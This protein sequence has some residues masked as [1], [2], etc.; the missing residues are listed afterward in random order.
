MLECLEKENQQ[1]IK[2]A[3]TLKTM[4]YQ[5]IYDSII[6]R[7]RTRGLDKNALDYYTEKHHA[8]PRCMGGSNDNSNLVLLTTREHY[9]CHLIL[10]VLHPDI[11]GLSCAVFFMVNNPASK[12]VDKKI[13]KNS[14]IFEQLRV[15]IAESKRGKTTSDKQKEAARR[16]GKENAPFKGKDMTG[17]NNLSAKPVRDSEGKIFPTTKACAKAHNHDVET[18]RYWCR[19]G[20]NGFSYI[21]REEAM[22]ELNINESAI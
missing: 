1:Y 6:E 5:K 9:I 21:S 22:K 2:I 8:T 13:A 20:K 16:I 14:R 19:A 7:G 10:A 12:S 15:N 3:H 18:I 4:N 17:W 11:P